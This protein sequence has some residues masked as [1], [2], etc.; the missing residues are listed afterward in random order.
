MA[1]SKDKFDQGMTTQEYIDYIKVNK[2]P[3]IDIYN[4]VEV[5]A[6]TQAFFDGLAEPLNLAV[7][8]SDWC[9]DA[10]STTP[11]VLKLAD[12]TD[13]LNLQVFSR[14]DELELT[15]SFL[16]EHRA[17]TVPV[18]VTFDAEMGEVSRFIETARSL[19]PQIDSMDDNIAQEVAAEGA[20]GDEVRAATRGKRTAFRVGKANDWGEMI[21]KEFQQLV[22]EGLEMAPVQRP[23]EGGT[24]WPPPEA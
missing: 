6:E 21:L 13:K 17:G 18:F 7:F 20:S 24:E 4:G 10:M 14:D 2:Q 23:S 3:F 8:T 15:N 1:L 12:S 22:A 16:P 19:V 9:G 5:P 11:A